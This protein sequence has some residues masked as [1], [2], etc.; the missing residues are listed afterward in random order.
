[1]RG[2]GEEGTGHGGRRHR[3]RPA[4]LDRGADRAAGRRA[5]GP[6]REH[7]GHLRRS[8]ERGVR[9]E[10]GAADHLH[11]EEGARRGGGAGNAA[12]SVPAR[13]RHV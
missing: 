1:E 3:R 4:A 2:G 13:A 12:R 5:Q 9:R 6:R 10:G 7:Q 8:E 11:P